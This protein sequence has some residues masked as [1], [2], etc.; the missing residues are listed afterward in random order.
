MEKRSE[1]CLGIGDTGTFISVVGSDGFALA[2]PAVTIPD[3]S[4]NA[5]ESRRRLQRFILLFDNLASETINKCQDFGFL[6][7]IDPIFIESL[8]HIISKSVKFIVR[9]LSLIHI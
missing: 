6:W 2:A 8:G 5:T 7:W 1:D 9:E 4:R 3:S